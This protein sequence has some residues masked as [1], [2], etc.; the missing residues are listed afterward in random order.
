MKSLSTND[1][2]SKELK[3]Y[4]EEIAN[5]ELLSFEEEQQI[6]TEIT[7][8]NISLKEKIIKANLKLVVAIAI[9]Y[10]CSKI[11]LIDLINDGNIGLINSVD[12]F[13]HQKGV[14]FSTFTYLY[15]RGA[16]LASIYDNYSTIRIPRHFWLNKP[17]SDITLEDCIQTHPSA[18]KVKLK[19]FKQLPLSN[20]NDHLIEENCIINNINFLNNDERRCNLVAELI[21]ILNERE[22]FIIK[23]TFGLNGHNTLTYETI[24]QKLGISKERVRILRNKALTKMKRVIDFFEAD[25]WFDE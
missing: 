16:I 2:Y 3:R 24:G 10:A 11:P 4:L 7:N 15:I 17:F 14:K 20:L 6:F 12:K 19:P 13:N 25:E 5:N 23:A 1:S 9:R 21:S 18:K 8:G 22:E